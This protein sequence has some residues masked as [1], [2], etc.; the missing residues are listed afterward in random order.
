MTDSGDV[1]EDLRLPDN[2]IGKEITDKLDKDE[3]IVVSTYNCDFKV[4][5]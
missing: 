1:K 3:G 4:F 2:D 5:I